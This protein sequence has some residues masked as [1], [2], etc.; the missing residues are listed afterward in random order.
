MS[1]GEW[2]ITSHVSQHL[3]ALKVY[4]GSIND[5]IPPH[6][7]ANIMEGI[8][9]ELEYQSKK[10]SLVFLKQDDPDYLDRLIRGS[11]FI[12]HPL[13]IHLGLDDDDKI[14]QHGLRLSFVNLLVTFPKETHGQS[15]HVPFRTPMYF[16]LRFH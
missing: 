15:H 4:L 13:N 7:D 6:N 10:G 16:F 9:E 8:E 5:I 3:H 12:E 2:N 11:D 14:D 1:G